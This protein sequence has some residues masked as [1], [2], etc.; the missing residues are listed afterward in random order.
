MH[1]STPHSAPCLAHL[2]LLE[3]TTRIICVKACNLIQVVKEN[4]VGDICGTYGGE[5]NFMH[6][7]GRET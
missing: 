1:L 7:F 4:Y 2:I 3:L 6:N 5:E